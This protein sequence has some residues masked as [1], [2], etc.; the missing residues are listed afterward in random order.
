M[1]DF[2]VQRCTRRCFQTEHE[3]KPGEEFYSVL[4]QE[5]AAVIRRDYSLAVWQGPPDE[6]LGCWKSQMP[7]ANARTLNWAPNDVML[8]YFQQLEAEAEKLE[9]RYVLTLLMIRRRIL[10][11]EETETDERGDEVMVV[12]CPRNEKEYRVSTR[13]PT[14]SR[15]AEIQSELS[16]LL[17]ADAS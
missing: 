1:L 9:V 7:D 5:G 11:L 3:F 10:R 4:L 6:A 2:D 14:Q 8:H 13:R 16:G 17:F 15:I 12:Y